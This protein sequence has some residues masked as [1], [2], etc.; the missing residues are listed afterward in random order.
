MKSSP[1]PT[2]PTL[3]P[4]TREMTGEDVKNNTTATSTNAT[5][6]DDDDDDDSKTFFRA[7]KSSSSLEE[8]EEEENDVAAK[9]R[10]RLLLDRRIMGV[11]PPT[12]TE[13][14]VAKATRLESVRV[15]AGEK[16]IGFVEN[17]RDLN[18]TKEE[19]A[20]HEKIVGRGKDLVLPEKGEALRE[21]GVIAEL[22]LRVVPLHDGLERRELLQLHPAKLA[23]LPTPTDHT[24]LFHQR[25]MKEGNEPKEEVG[26]S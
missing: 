11:P 22:A 5:N 12:T 10:R 21:L 9:K 2:K 15:V 6:E 3:P 17:E 19:E 25:V 7:K 18:K 8:E 13:T 23:H 1:R 20:E 16:K 4:T 24:L 26:P 14:K